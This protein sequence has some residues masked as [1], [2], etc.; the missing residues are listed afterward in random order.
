MRLAS[1]P[2]LVACVL[3]AGAGRPR[4]KGKTDLAALQGSWV[5]VE[6]EF[7]GK[8][9]AKEEVARLKGEMIIEKNVVSQWAE[10]LGEKRLVSRSTLKL[11]PKARPRHM[12]MTYT[13]GDLKGKTVLGIYELNGDTLKACYSMEDEKRPTEFAGKQDGK[14][15]LLIY[16]RVKK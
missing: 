14:A 10:D 7:M 12:D 13:G 8:K 1:L 16:K 15:F 4:E 6:K 11:D 2:I 3:A 9:A 5:I